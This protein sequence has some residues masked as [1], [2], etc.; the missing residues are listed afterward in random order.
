MGVAVFRLCCSASTATSTRSRVRHS[1]PARRTLRCDARFGGCDAQFGMRCAVGMR[2]AGTEAVVHGGGRLSSTC[3]SA[4]PLSE[5]ERASERARERERA[6]VARAMLARSMPSSTQQHR[7][8][9]GVPTVA[10]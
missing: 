3:S 1:A 2:C 4:E 10:V 8:G 5:R 9:H 7:G 6:S